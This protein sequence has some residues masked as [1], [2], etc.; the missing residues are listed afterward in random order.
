M[1]DKDSKYFSLSGDIPIGG[2][3]TWQSIDWDQRRVVSVTMDGEQDDESLAIE[4]FSRHSNQLSPD[5][6]RIYV[7]HNGEINSTYTDSKNGPTCCVHYPSL[8]DACPPEEVQIVRRDKLEE[9]E[10]LGPDADL[11]AYSPCIE[12]SAK[13]GVFKYY[14]L[15]QYA[16]MSWKEMNLWM[17]LPC[18]PNIVPFDQVVVDELEGRIVGFTSNYVPGGNLEENKSRVFKLKWLQQLIKV[19]D[20]LNLGPGIAHQDIAP[21]NLLI[22]ESTDSIMLFDFNFA[23]RINCPSSGEGESYVEE[24]NDI[25]GVIFT[26]YEIIT[27]DDSLRSIPHEDQNLDNLELK[28]V[29]HPEVKLDHP[30]ESYQLMLK[31]WRERR[32]RDSRSGNVPRLIDWPAMPKPP[33][34]TISLKTVQGQT[35]SVTVDNWYERRQDIRGRGDKVLN[36]ERPPQRLLDNGIRVLSTGEILN[37]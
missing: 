3:S 20:E 34:K 21:R 10:R 15:W 28:W 37:C 13:K 32:E 24:R 4:H 23:A 9:L 19:V 29:T 25:K 31:E 26:T 6:H 12:G 27:Q 7:S 33:Q 14:F 2:P 22:N 35:T 8:H 17:R 5:I 36:W 1:I 30:V 11:V 16:Q 18:N